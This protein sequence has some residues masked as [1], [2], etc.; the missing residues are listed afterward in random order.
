MVT[1]GLYSGFA[2]IEGWPCDLPV[3][4][5]VQ[6]GVLPQSLQQRV[7]LRAVHDV[8]VDGDVGFPFQRKCIKETAIQLPAHSQAWVGVGVHCRGFVGGLGGGGFRG[9]WDRP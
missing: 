3:V 7:E 4:P 1:Q 8:A 9:L 6:L 5:L 2:S